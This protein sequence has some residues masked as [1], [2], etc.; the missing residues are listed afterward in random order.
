MI[1]KTAI[2]EVIK[3]LSDL[4]FRFN[5]RRT[6]D[7]QFFTE[8]YENLTEITDEEKVSLD[9]IRRRYLYHLAD[10]NLTEGT[11]TLL[12]GSPLLEKA[13]FYDY[14]F[15]MR[16]EASV[17]IVLDENDEDVETLR[18]RIDILVLQNQFWVTLLESKRTTISVLSALPQTLA[19]MIASSQTDKPVFGMITNGNEILFVKLSQQG[20][21]QYDV[22]DIFSP[23]PLRNRLYSVLQILKS[24]GQI[25]K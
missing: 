6:E 7:E 15:K 23:V 5:L 20:T 22:S 2:T 25:I 14:P 24:I 12:I 3:T 4:E 13:G 11:V 18:G 17:E 9:V 8:W 10:G 21:P 16:G 1:Q 19:Y